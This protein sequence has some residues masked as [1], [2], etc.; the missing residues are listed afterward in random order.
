MHPAASPGDAALFPADAPLVLPE[1][2]QAALRAA[3][4]VPTRAYHHIGHVA[5]VLRHWAWAGTQ[6][7]WHAPRETWLAV[8]Y[9]DAVYV[10]GRSDNE[11]ASAALLAAHAE[12]WPPAA[13]VDLAF[14]QAMILATARH[15]ALLPRDLDGLAFPDD[16]RRFLDCDMAVLGA[17]PEVFAAYDRGIAE[18]YRAVPRWLYRRK[19]RAFFRMLL[20]RERIYLSDLFHAR[21]DAAARTNLAAAI[22]NGVAS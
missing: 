8:L 6:V 2:Q 5:E 12:R 7:P 20:G 21:F 14:A 9:H 10:P 4:A 18:E 22:A 13:P 11:A 3:Y 1:A 19:R 17:P 16:A 15:G